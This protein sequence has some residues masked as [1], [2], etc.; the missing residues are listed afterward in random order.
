MFIA[1]GTGI[2]IG[3]KLKI[4]NNVDIARTIAH[5]LGLEMTTD[6]RILKEALAR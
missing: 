2:K 3:V 6:G 5:L 1:A 4:I